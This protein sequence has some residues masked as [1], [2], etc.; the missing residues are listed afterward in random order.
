MRSQEFEYFDWLQIKSRSNLVCN[1]IMFASKLHSCFLFIPEYGRFNI[2]VEWQNKGRDFNSIL[3]NTHTTQR[4]RGSRLLVQGRLQLKIP[5]I[6]F[7]VFYLSDT[8]TVSFEIHIHLNGQPALGF[9]FKDACSSKF[10]ISDVTF[11]IQ[12]SKDQ[13]WIM[14]DS[15]C[16]VLIRR[17]RNESILHFPFLFSFHVGTKKCYF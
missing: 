1:R 7:K 4:S 3:R 6:P 12:L 2:S 13:K 11:K 10:Q 15:N 17:P 14:N 16:I 8:P 5:D 9:W